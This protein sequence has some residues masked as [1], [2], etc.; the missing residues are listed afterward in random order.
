MFKNTFRDLIKNI[1]LLN[2]LLKE[3]FILSR[4]SLISNKLRSFLSL[5]GVSIGIFSVI[6]VFTFIDGLERS[7]RDSVQSI[8]GNVIYIQKWPWAFGEDYPWW[9]YLERPLPKFEEWAELKKILDEDKYSVTY[10]VNV[11]SRS[12]IRYNKNTISEFRIIGCTYEYASVRGLNLLCGRYFSNSEF[13]QGKNVIIIGHTIAKNLF[14][15]PELAVNQEIVYNGKKLRIIGVI[16]KEGKNIFNSSL[17]EIVLMP[18]LFTSKFLSVKSENANPF[19][20]V[21]PLLENIDETELLSTLKFQMRKI[22]RLKP[23]EED[24][25]ALNQS[26]LIEKNTEGLFTVLSL[27]GW[28]I[29]GFSILVAGFGIANIMFVSVKERVPIIGIQKALGATKVFILLQFLIESIILT[30][31]GGSIGLIITYIT[32][33]FIQPYI[34]L[35]IRLS[36]D[37][38]LLAINISVL[39]GIISGFIPAYSASQLDPVESMREA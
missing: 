16:Q 38:I 7:I 20:A 31:L 11:F 24:N 25:F 13:N 9:K 19:I 14:G 39:I 15:S 18:Y 28:I 23:N 17:D 4:Q 36:A 6:L 21:K 22:R 37:N 8:G 2:W 10:C 3:A 27:A 26:S 1:G 5:L 32:I 34:D 35:N 29:G 12:P 33:Y 30:I